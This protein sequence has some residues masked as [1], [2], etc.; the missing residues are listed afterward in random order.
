MV[1]LLTTYRKW[2]YRE[3]CRFLLKPFFQYRDRILRWCCCP[4]RRRLWQFQAHLL[5]CRTALHKILLCYSVCPNIKGSLS[6]RNT[7]IAGPWSGGAL[8]WGT[9]SA[10]TKSY[11]VALNTASEE[12]RNTLN[13]NASDSSSFFKNNINA[14]QVAS[15]RSL[16]LVRAY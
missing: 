4:T 1:V 2:Y 12:L 11:P 6:L 14:V 16:V 13:L 7:V 3:T 9:E 10:A 15:L 8:S 5:R